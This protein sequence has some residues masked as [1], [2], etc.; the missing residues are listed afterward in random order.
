MKTN[1]IFT[2]GGGGGGAG[3]YRKKALALISFL[4]LSVLFCR[5]FN[6]GSG[7]DYAPFLQLHG[8]TCSSM[9]YVSV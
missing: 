1:S 8:I 2:L 6:L 3:G 5:I 4:F 7:S 9:A